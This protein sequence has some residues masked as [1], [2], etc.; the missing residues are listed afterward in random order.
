MT[1]HTQL[2]NKLGGAGKFRAWKY[3]ISL[4]LEE[5]DLDQDISKEAQGKFF[6]KYYILV[7]EFDYNMNKTIRSKVFCHS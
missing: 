5:N 6:W 1:H 7:Y 2:A 4:I 3:K